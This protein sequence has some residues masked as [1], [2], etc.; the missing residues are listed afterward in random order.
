M[1]KRVLRYK[2]KKR[3]IR[4]M[5]KP[6]VRHFLAKRSRCAG[7][8]R[9][10]RR[11]DPCEREIRQKGFGPFGLGVREPSEKKGKEGKM[12]ETITAWTRQV[13]QV[14]DEICETG[15]YRVLEEYV[16]AKNMDISDYYISLY[17]WLTDRSRCYVEGIPDDAEFPVWL[18]MTEA[19]RLG[20]AP[21]TISLTLEIPRERVFLIDYDK[22][23]YIVNHFYLPKDAEDE[24]RHNEELK[25]MGIGNEA[26]LI[27]T[28]KGNYYPALKQKILRSW[29]RLFDGPNEN[30]DNNVGVIWEIKPEWVVEVERY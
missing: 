26:Q 17:R 2:S 19:Q 20:K 7:W 11:P 22:W 4:G 1:A 15:T 10:M 30:M 21:G 23:G 3:P 16:R 25:M 24:R 9:M 5:G 14:W 12:P 13:P 18:A 8:Y 27:S 29:D 28:D 6:S